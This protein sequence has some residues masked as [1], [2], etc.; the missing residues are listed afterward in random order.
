MPRGKT[1]HSVES[2]ITK[3]NEGGEIKF[4]DEETR[5]RAV[6]CIQKRGKIK[7]TSKKVK[8]KELPTKVLWAQQ[9]D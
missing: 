5:K 1:K 9:V 2:T 3:N 6:E 4:L 8:S 7:I